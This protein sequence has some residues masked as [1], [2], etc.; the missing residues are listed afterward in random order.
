MGVA[1]GRVGESEEVTR[2]CDFVVTF[3]VSKIGAFGATLSLA[4]TGQNRTALPAATL[5]FSGTGV[6]SP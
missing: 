5:P 1:L 6:A 3:T 4:S 2:S